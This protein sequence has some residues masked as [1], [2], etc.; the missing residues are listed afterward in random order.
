MIP[1]EIDIMN[2][3]DH[4]NVVKFYESFEDTRTGYIWIRIFLFVFSFL[5]SLLFQVS[6]PLPFPVDQICLPRHGAL[7]WWGAVRVDPRKETV[8]GGDSLSRC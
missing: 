4:L 6:E 1:Q 7:W 8:L 3:L 2:M 5:S